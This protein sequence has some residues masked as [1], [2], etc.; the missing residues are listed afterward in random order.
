[1]R[2]CVDSRVSEVG[3]QESSVPCMGGGHRLNAAALRH[4]LTDRS[5]YE[6][7]ETTRREQGRRAEMVAV[8]APVYAP[9]TL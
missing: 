9:W 7:V 5:A 6:I 8:S 2:K 4:L 3:M 1:M